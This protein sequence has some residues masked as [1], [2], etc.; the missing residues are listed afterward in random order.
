MV[1]DFVERKPHTMLRMTQKSRIAFEEYRR[2]MDRF[3]KVCPKSLITLKWL[4]V[5]PLL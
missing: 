2:E 4:P 5:F 1:K 3:F